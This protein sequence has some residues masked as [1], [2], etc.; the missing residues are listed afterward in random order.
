MP[1]RG[2][3]RP[4]RSKVCGYAAA[5]ALSLVL[6]ACDASPSASDDDCGRPLRL[7]VGEAA[8]VQASAECPLR[9]EGGAEY[10]LAY[11]DASLAQGAQAQPEPY[12]APDD[13]FVAL[14][15]DVTGGTRAA[16]SIMASADLV[17]AAAPGD[18][19]LSL[20]TGG[21]SRVAGMPG[22]G[23]WAVG[24]EIPR[25]RLDCVANCVP[26]TTARVARIMDNWLVFAVD[27]SL[28]P[29]T[30]RV[31]S[32]FDQAAPLLRQHALPLL[33]AAFTP[34]RPVTT[35]VSGQL[36]VVFE[37]DLTRGGG[38]AHVEIRPDG[39]ATHW[40]RLELSSDLD[41][42]KMLWLLAH[43]IAHTYQYEFLA[44]TPPSAGLR[45]AT[46][47]GRWGIE[48]GA[49]LVD[50]E[51]LRRAAGVPLQGNVDYRAQAASEV[52]SWLFRNGGARGGVLTAGY[53]S[54]APFLRDLV[55]RRMDAGEPAE[56]AFREVLRG[57]AEGWYGV[58]NE[59]TRRTGL[60]ERMRARI[61]GWTPEDAVLTWTLG[62]AADD[63]VGGTVFQ[64][65]A[66]L[67]TGD[68]ERRGDGWEYDQLIEAGTG[69]TARLT[70]PVGTSG[71]LLVR[72]PAGR[73]E[74]M[75][76]GAETIR[77]KLLR[78]S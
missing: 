61:S 40:I 66:W 45:S 65:R 58:G 9:A 77:W 55:F 60:V 75:L 54:A 30:E 42:G 67:R 7:A 73:V 46:G 26:Y 38:V 48:G 29:D 69:A 10:V 24:D 21:P 33:D 27:P 12:M 70:R 44:R 59:S 5:A 78:V 35:A 13:R 50:M 72:A 6:S 11:Y 41:A 8:Q 20:G 34:A 3:P 1:H 76:G 71:Y 56:T 15:N 51:T 16:P 43:E 22:T 57:A 53:Y 32:L 17:R 52:E 14:V 74:L 64:D 25:T 36:V 23:P 62:A 19:H 18:V 63:R 49:T 2:I 31:L 68:W 28:G 47:A 39:T 37:G 4:H